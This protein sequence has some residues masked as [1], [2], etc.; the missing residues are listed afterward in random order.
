MK[1][2]SGIVEHKLRVTFG[3][4]VLALPASCSA[5]ATGVT[6][7]W[8]SPCVLQERTHSAV[9]GFSCDKRKNQTPA[10]HSC[11]VLVKGQSLHKAYGLPCRRHFMDRNPW[12]MEH[13]RM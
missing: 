3:I 6:G 1:K 10:H 13:M 11:D 9:I 8:P 4:T 12:F 2:D 7:L 5:V